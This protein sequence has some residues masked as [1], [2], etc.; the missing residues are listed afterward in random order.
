MVICIG[1][2]NPQSKCLQITTRKLIKKYELHIL[3]VM[4]TFNYLSTIP[5]E[6]LPYLNNRLLTNY[7]WKGLASIPHI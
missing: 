5:F 3:F 4:Q 1:Q 2:I 7:L 6:R